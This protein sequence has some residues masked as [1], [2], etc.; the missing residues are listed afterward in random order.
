MQRTPPC[1]K[2]SP[3]KLP[4][5]P[6][7]LSFLRPSCISPQMAQ[8]FHHGA[9]NLNLI[10]RSPISFTNSCSSS[11][12]TGFPPKYFVWNSPT[13]SPWGPASSFTFLVGATSLTT[14]TKGTLPFAPLSSWTRGSTVFIS[15]YASFLQATQPARLTTW[16]TA[17]VSRQSSPALTGATDPS[18]RVPFCTGRSGTSAKTEPLTST[19]SAQRFVAVPRCAGALADGP[20]KRVC[21]GA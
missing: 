4:S 20:A 2:P 17:P 19:G 5:T 13:P 14:A 9:L 11:Q 12:Y 7:S 1:V 10:F 18:T 6:L 21:R 3:T 8:G 16:T 15:S